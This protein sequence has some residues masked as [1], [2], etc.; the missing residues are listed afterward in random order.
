MKNCTP[1]LI[2]GQKLLTWNENLVDNNGKGAKEKM[3]KYRCIPCGYIYDPEVGDPDGGIAPGTEFEDIPD[4]WQCPICFV[5]K[6]EFEVA[7]E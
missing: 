7:D 6:D 2:H 5:S 4:D 1:L 3:N